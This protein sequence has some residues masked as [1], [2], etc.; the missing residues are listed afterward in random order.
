M[1]AALSGT[2]AGELKY[3]AYISETSTSKPAEEITDSSMWTVIGENTVQL[4]IPTEGNGSQNL[5]SFDLPA[6]SWFV[7]GTTESGVHWLNAV[8]LD[9]NDKIIDNDTEYVLVSSV[10]KTVKTSLLS[11]VVDPVGDTSVAIYNEIHGTFPAGT[12]NYK[13]FITSDSRTSA[14]SGTGSPWVIKNGS[15]GQSFDISSSDATSALSAHQLTEFY[16]PVDQ[17]TAVGDHFIKTVVSDSAGTELCSDTVKVTITSESVTATILAN[18]TDYLTFVRSAAGTQPIKIVSIPSITKPNIVYKAELLISIAGYA[19]N[20]KNHSADNGSPFAQV[21]EWPNATNSAPLTDGTPLTFYWDT[22][23][24]H[25]AVGNHQILLKIYNQATN[26]LVGSEYIY[27]K[28]CDGTNCGTTGVV[29]PGDDSKI[30][31]KN[32]LSSIGIKVNFESYTSVVTFIKDTWFPIIIGMFA[33][34]GII[35]SGWLYIL[36]AGDETKANKGKKGLL[37]SVIGIAIAVLAQAIISVSKS[38]INT[39]ND[40]TSVVGPNSIFTKATGQIAIISGMLAFIYLV[41][42]GILYLTSSG[43]PDNA[44]KGLQGVINAAI[45]IV[46]IVAAWAIIGAVTG[47]LR[48]SF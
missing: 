33:F 32:A 20:T 12:Y 38:T 5:I 14:P 9:S 13:I 19:E 23:A 28:I 1:S 27:I 25:S 7:D 47:T 43:N 44:K 24:N 29:T 21:I 6:V 48:A 30:N 41:Y 35:Y 36:S 3:K 42:S 2:F 45:G 26:A 11:D 15:T 18:G 40:A 4:P 37:Y 34:F 22:V 39:F 10:N 46:I 8:I 31:L 17:N 16:W